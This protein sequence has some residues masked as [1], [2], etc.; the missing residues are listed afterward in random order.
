MGGLIGVF[1]GLILV[2]IMSGMGFGITGIIPGRFNGAGGST[3]TVTPEL[4]LFALAFATIIGII[5]GLI[6]AKKASSLQIVEAMRS[7]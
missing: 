1:L 4:I 3:I 6:P 7:E 5:S 2:G